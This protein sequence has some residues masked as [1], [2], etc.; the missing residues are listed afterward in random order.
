M[1]KIELA[2]ETEEQ[3]D[4]ILELL[5]ENEEDGVLDFAFNT[6]VIIPNPQSDDW[7]ALRDALNEQKAVDW[8][9]KRR[10]R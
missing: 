8:A 7:F 2:V 9:L 1:Y 5:R 3:K 6:Q 10:P 4:Q